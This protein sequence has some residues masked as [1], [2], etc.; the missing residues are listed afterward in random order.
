MGVGV[1]SSDFDGS[2]GTFLVSG[3]LPGDNEDKHEFENESNDFAYDLATAIKT[4]ST[5]LGM[6]IDNQAKGLNIKNLAG[7]DNDFVGVAENNQVGV[8]WRSWEHDFVVGVGGLQ[9][10][11]NWAYDPDGN[12]GEIIQETGFPQDKAIDAY[13]VIADNTLE[14][15]RL[16]LME[17]GFE[18]RFRTSGY[19]TG[20]YEPPEEGFLQKKEELKQKICEAT[21]LLNMPVNEALASSTHEDR[22]AIAKVLCQEYRPSIRPLVLAYDASALSVVLYDMEDPDELVSITAIPPNVS[23]FLASQPSDDSKNSLSVFPH[24]QETDAFI[25]ALQKEGKYKY[26]DQLLLT[27]EEYT[28]ATNNDC[29]VGDNCVL[30]EDDGQLMAACI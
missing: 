10:W 19:T 6:D 21:A 16:T 12:A 17:E 11:K 30:F 27:A 3:P 8:G 18:C 23:A 15:I 7:F 25:I 22:V 28:M 24:T 29:V 4:A 1:Y 14:Y 9:D 2:G 13:H 5:K 26:C 20:L